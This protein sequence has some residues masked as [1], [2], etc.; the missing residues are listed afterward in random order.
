[1]SLGCGKHKNPAFWMSW[2]KSR[3]PEEIAREEDREQRRAARSARREADRARDRYEMLREQ[4]RNGSESRERK[5]EMLRQSRVAKREWGHYTRT[6]EQHESLLSAGKRAN[7]RAQAARYISIVNERIEAA[8]AEVSAEEVKEQLAL[9]RQNMVREGLEE[10]ELRREQRGI[11]A[12]QD[13]PD[14]AGSEDEDID[15]E[16]DELLGEAE[17]EVA[18]TQA[19]DLRRLQAELQGTEG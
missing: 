7:D 15:A 5:R 9:L 12:I 6:A 14:D 3:D 1:M 11:D 13:A 19:V 4:V 8:R 16:L 10:A 17:D 18:Q 2:W